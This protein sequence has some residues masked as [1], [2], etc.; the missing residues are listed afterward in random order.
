MN[1]NKTKRRRLGASMRRFCVG[2]GFA[3]A[4]Y[5]RYLR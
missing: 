2:L 4:A 5:W 1:Q 3:G